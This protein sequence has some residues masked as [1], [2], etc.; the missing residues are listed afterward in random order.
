[1]SDD[2]PILGEVFG[3]RA[4]R[5]IFLIFLIFGKPM[6][7]CLHKLY[8]ITKTWLMMAASNTNATF[9]DRMGKKG[10]GWKKKTT[11]VSSLQHILCVQG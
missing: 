7:V 4:G 2:D 6:C 9:L 8:Y 10:N 3:F 11:R 5:A 1:M